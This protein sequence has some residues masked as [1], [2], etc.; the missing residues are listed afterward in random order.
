MEISSRL[1]LLL[2][3]DELRSDSTTTR[4]IVEVLKTLILV[5]GEKKIEL[6]K[7]VD[8]I[9]HSCRVM[10]DSV[11]RRHSVTSKLDKLYS[12][13][14]EFSVSKGFEL[15]QTCEKSLELKVPQ[16]LW[17][18]LMEKEFIDSLN[19]SLVVADIM[20]SVNQSTTDGTGRVI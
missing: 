19:S 14:H 17:Q 20:P 13:I 9:R 7:L 1:E 5:D 15:C 4:E 11:Q 2:E 3:L 8:Q 16:I 6:Q 10:L 18:L 12:L